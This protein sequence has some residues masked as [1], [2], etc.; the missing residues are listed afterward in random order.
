MLNAGER[1][2]GQKIKVE[3]GCADFNDFSFT[4]CFFIMNSIIA[5]ERV[6]EENSFPLACLN[7][8]RFVKVEKCSEAQL[9]YYG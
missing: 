2:E 6:Y 7:E 9:A 3:N 5:V 1:G 8:R 4:R